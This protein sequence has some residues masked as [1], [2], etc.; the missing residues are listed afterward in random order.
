MIWEHVK[1]CGRICIGENEDSIVA[2]DVYLLGFPSIKAYG[3]YA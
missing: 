2:G 1:A 3:L